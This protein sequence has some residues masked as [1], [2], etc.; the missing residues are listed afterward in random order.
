MCITIIQL[1]LPHFPLHIV[2]NILLFTWCNLATGLLFLLLEIKWNVVNDPHKFIGVSWA[3]CLVAHFAACCSEISHS[4]VLIHIH[5]YNFFRLCSV[6]TLGA[7]SYSLFS[8]PDRSEGGLLRLSVWYR[9]V[10]VETSAQS[11]WAVQNNEQTWLGST[12]LEVNVISG[13]GDFWT[14]RGCILFVT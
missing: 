10:V 4:G 3:V 7:V 13:I 11:H 6:R 9:P 12:S 5:F 8:L 14:C 2:T 1:Q